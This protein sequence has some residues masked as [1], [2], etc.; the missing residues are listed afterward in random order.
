VGYR[1]YDDL[2]GKLFGNFFQV[3]LEG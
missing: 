1:Q 3:V 2:A